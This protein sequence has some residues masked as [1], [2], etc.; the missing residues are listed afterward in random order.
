M[1]LRQL[2]EL[3]PIVHNVIKTPLKQDLSKYVTCDYYTWSNDKGDYVLRT[4]TFYF[5]KGQFHT[6]NLDSYDCA[7]WIVTIHDTQGIL[8]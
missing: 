1:N 6:V 2:A 7:D 8:R 4:G 5:H 3:S